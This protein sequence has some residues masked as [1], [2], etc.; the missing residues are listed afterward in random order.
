MNCHTVYSKHWPLVTSAF[1]KKKKKNYL[2]KRGQR[3]ALDSENCNLEK[4]YEQSFPSISFCIALYRAKPL[5][6]F[7]FGRQRYWKK[8]QAKVYIL[9]A[10]ETQLK[11]HK[12]EPNNSLVTCIIWVRFFQQVFCL[13]HTPGAALGLIATLKDETAAWD[14]SSWV[15]AF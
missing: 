12:M 11:E 5:T 8:E 9:G 2:C 14:F 7:Q 15:L 10:I 1:L 4:I 3:V 6:F 13:L